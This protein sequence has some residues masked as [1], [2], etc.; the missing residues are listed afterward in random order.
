MI[1]ALEPGGEHIVVQCPHPDVYHAIVDVRACVNPRKTYVQ[2]VSSFGLDVAVVAGEPV[3]M[4]F[5]NR[6]RAAVSET[7][8]LSGKHHP[9][10]HM[11]I[12]TASEIVCARIVANRW[13]LEIWS[14]P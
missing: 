12:S 4:L 13:D 1:L 2:V 11:V 14:I 10:C 3:Y 5:F 8:R 9:S 6:C 7:L